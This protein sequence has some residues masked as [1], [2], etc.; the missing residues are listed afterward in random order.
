MVAL[1]FGGYLTWSSVVVP[2]HALAGTM[3]TNSPSLQGQ[4]PTITW[5][6]TGQAAIGAENF[7][8]LA[9]HNTATPLP[10]ASVTKLIT[11]LCVLSKHP[12]GPNENGPTI[13]ITE[14]DVANYRNYVA[15]HGSVLPVRVGQKLTQRQA[16]EALLLR[17]ANNIADTLAV[18]SFG[19][20]QDYA[21]YANQFVASKG[22]PNTH[23][24]KDASG[25]D[26]TTVSTADDLV[27]LGE[28]VM[29]EPVLAT[30]VGQKTATI[31]QVGVIYNTNNLLGRE[32]IVGIKTGNN[33][34]DPG[35]YLFASRYI[36][37]T[38][39]PV[40]IIGAV[41]G[42]KDLYSA[43]ASAVQLLKSVRDE[44]VVRTVVHQGQ[45]VGSY[46]VAWTEPAKLIAASDLNIFG[47]RGA[48][49][50]TTI[51]L[52]AAKPPI[53]YRKKVGTIRLTDNA[54]ATK[55][56]LSLSRAITAP[57]LSWRLTHPLE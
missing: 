16:L 8:V 29:D 55:V 22:L 50:G 47:W 25:L 30:I 27:R 52:D 12:L 57:P 23:V 9:E 15:N 46:D 11:A 33:D 41:M 20:L 36:A 39:H 35:V 45:T 53:A 48:D 13:T 32:G 7:G 24:G 56:N 1:L 34:E 49:V 17:S 18:W 2:R 44:F 10:T 3:H 42:A 5:P 40:T 43:K 14:R 26:P 28:L 54:T 21:A 37:A 4:K 38:D 51:T 19:T 31:P 6:T